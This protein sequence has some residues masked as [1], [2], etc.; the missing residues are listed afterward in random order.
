MDTYIYVQHTV[1]SAGP[2]GALVP[3]LRETPVAPDAHRTFENTYVLSPSFCTR[4]LSS[5]SSIA[6]PMWWTELNVWTDSGDSAATQDVA[7]SF[8]HH[9]GNCT[10]TVLSFPLVFENL[11]LIHM[12]PHA[13]AQPSESSAR[14]GILQLISTL[15]R[16]HL[17]VFGNVPDRP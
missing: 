11:P 13:V 14:V 2:L 17:G 7:F 4:N 10:R 8:V 15:V 6:S 16:R 3:C 5:P 9:P 1:I 12:Y